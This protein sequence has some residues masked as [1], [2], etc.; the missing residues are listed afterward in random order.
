[1]RL[2]KSYDRKNLFF[3]LLVYFLFPLTLFASN[4]IKIATTNSILNDLNKRNNSDKFIYK[5]KTT[6]SEEISVKI[7][8]FIN[9]KEY[10]S[11]KGKSVQS[12]NSSCMLKGD[13]NNIYG[14]IVLNDEN[15]AYE[16]TSNESK[17][18]FVEEVPV[19]KIFPI[20]KVQGPIEE[21]NCPILHRFD[22][23][24]HLGDY[25][26]G[27]DVTKLQS[28]PGAS[29]TIYLDVT[30]A[31]NG[32]EP[33]SPFTKAHIWQTWQS[34]AAALIVWDVNITTDASVYNAALSS[35]VQ[36]TCIARHMY[37]TGR[38]F[39]P[40]HSFGSTSYSTLYRETNGYGQGRTAAHEIGHQ[41]GL[42]H[43]GSPGQ[44]YYPGISSFRWVP[45]MGNYWSG[46]SWGNDALYQ[47]S[48][49]EYSGANNRE[50]DLDMIEYYIPYKDDDKPSVTPLMFTNGM[51]IEGE[52]NYGRIDR[53]TDTDEFSFKI[54]GSGGNVDIVI[55][56][57]EYIGGSLL[58]VEAEILDNSGNSIAVS[59]ASVARYAEFSNLSLDA[60][61]YIL[62]V[63]GGAEGSPSN[64]FSNYSSLGYY[65]IEGKITGAG[66]DTAIFIS[67]PKAD[68]SYEHGNT[69][70]ITWYDNIDDDVK[71][72]LNKNG[73]E[74]SEIAALTESDG[75]F[76][77]EIP[78]DVGA[79][80]GFTVIVAS[81]NGTI[82]DTSGEFK[83]T[84]E[85]IISQFP[86]KEEFDGLDTNATTLPEGWVQEQDDEL[87]WLVWKGPTP[88]KIGTAPDITG[89]DG[90]YPSGNGN[91]I[92]VEASGEN[93][94]GKSA[95][96]L[97]P[98]FRLKDNYIL[99]FWCHMFSDSAMMGDFNFDIIADGVENNE[100]VL[101]S[102]DSGD[103][104]FEVKVD[105]KDY[106]GDR[107]RFRIDG[108]TGT[109]WASDICF[110]NIVIDKATAANNQILKS[111]ALAASVVG[112]SI[113]YTIPEQLDNS[114]AKISL[115][116]LKGKMIKTLFKGKAKSGNFS[117]NMKD[118]DIS[119]GYYLCRINI[120][121]SKLVLPIIFN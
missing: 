40:L 93:N 106:Q 37:E 116:N 16:Y 85:F 118:F 48:I 65:S 38:S 2:F 14:W 41:L 19:T 66:T 97:S 15:R 117:F 25:P 34:V 119:S 29:K 11:L 53:N 104:W 90:D 62:E 102:K 49:G 108:T 89:P 70:K 12:E 26:A 4:H 52:N 84:E 13:E 39:A 69:C 60:G 58:D 112:K 72:T 107:V 114:N 55:D 22:D 81:L 9:Q 111:N 24:V 56:R 57:I 36:N 105:L 115:Y 47:W 7:E 83:L 18:V 109:G 77:W 17:D 67:T 91:F 103:A 54:T 46:N 95:V 87:D 120:G 88:S 1:M 101:F 75:E 10:F 30:R 59:N 20:C 78:S 100:V 32:S 44:E 27:T 92:Y 5:F 80:N 33:K 94:P 50:D 86:Y 23:L 98:K 6:R 71:I 64:G 21:A 61:S 45:I 79:G 3:T 73:S 42:S 35:N 51:D 8:E 110:D 28:L 99:S 43:D 31:M 76:E 121:K 74:V 96:V 68:D 113:N 82:A 63:R